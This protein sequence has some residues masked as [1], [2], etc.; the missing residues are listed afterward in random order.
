MNQLSFFEDIDEKEMRRLVVK[1]L[2][3]YKALCVRMKNQEEQAQAGGIVLFPKMKG[4]D[5][6]HEIRFKQTERTLQYALDEDERKIIEMKYLGNRK[7][8]D[9]FVYN[10]LMMKRDPFYQKK[11]SAIQLI[12]TALGII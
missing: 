12:A 9:S 4:D 8:K 3:N 1:E 7:V 2:K 5:K 10:E 6:N 11:K